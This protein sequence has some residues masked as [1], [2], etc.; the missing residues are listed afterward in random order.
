MEFEFLKY[1]RK[2]ELGD[3]ELVF[4]WVYCMVAHQRLYSSLQKDQK[5]LQG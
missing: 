4:G 5:A 3:L 1:K 2:D